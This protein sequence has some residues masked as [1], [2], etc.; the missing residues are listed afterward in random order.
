MDSVPDK[1]Y[2]WV[3]TLVES[4]KYCNNN[5]VHVMDSIPDQY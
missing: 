1:Y 5:V 2:E 3:G 4:L